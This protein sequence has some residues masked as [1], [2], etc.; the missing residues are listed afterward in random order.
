[1]LHSPAKTCALFMCFKPVR[2]LESPDGHVYSQVVFL[3]N[4]DLTIPKITFY[5]LHF[6]AKIFQV[7]NVT[8]R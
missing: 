2:N 1:M 6:L 4:R 8:K 7:K 3:I 5:A